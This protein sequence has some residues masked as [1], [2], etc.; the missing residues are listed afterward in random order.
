MLACHQVSFCQI[1]ENDDP[2]IRL[3]GRSVIARALRYR[4]LLGPANRLHSLQCRRR[5]EVTWKY[6]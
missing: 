5:G 3:M 2:E 1:G 6:G 4:F